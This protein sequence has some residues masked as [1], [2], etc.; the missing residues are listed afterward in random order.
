MLLTSL[1]LNFVDWILLILCFS[2]FVFYCLA[3]YAAFLHFKPQTI[4]FDF[5]PPVTIL[6]PICGLDADAYVNLASFCQQDYPD[7]QII[8]SVRDANDPAIPLI[9]RIIH[10][11]PHLDTQL[12]ICDRV[13]G[14]NL[15]VSNLA[16]A[17]TFAKHDILFVVD[18]DIRVGKDYLRCVIQPLQDPQVSVITCPYRAIADDWVTRLQ[19]I[20]SAT[21]FH[22]GVLVSNLT[23]GIKY[24]FGSTIVIRK[25]V[26][27]SIG[28]FH[29]IADYL[30]DD[31]Q[32]GY[33]PSQAGHKVVLSNY[34][35]DHVLATSTISD[36][37]NQQ[38]RWAKCI[39][40][41]RPWG[42][43]GLVFTY[44][45]IT[46][47]LLL[48]STH[49]SII[50]W[51]ELS[52]TLATRLVMAWVVGVYSLKDASSKKY[53]WLV[54]IRDLLSFMIWCLGFIGD[55]ITWRGQ[56]L[57]LIS[58]GKLVVLPHN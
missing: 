37:F 10:D 33:L 49:A 19:A 58:G 12:V 35:V 46:S 14:A 1:N 6:K 38:I 55:R 30:A 15:K 26:L 28:S 20:G 31:F 50:S 51:M 17:V 2:A 42:Y 25:Q 41:S 47:I 27:N 7:Y 21:D 16:N 4:D 57:R 32:L 24:A 53:L 13:I 44:G 40:V 9:Q 56:K 52:L 22:A 23:E 18:S 3:I 36:A 11:F 34:V 5:H 54:P 45:I 8:F 48:I 43:I 29:A 39:R